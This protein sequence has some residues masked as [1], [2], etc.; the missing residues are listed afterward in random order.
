MYRE[1]NNINM[2]EQALHLNINCSYG[3][4]KYGTKSYNMKI[5][6]PADR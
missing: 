1:S 5:Y 6:F 4:L 2:V 3:N